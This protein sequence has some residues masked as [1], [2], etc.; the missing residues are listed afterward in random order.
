MTPFFSTAKYMIN[1]LFSAKSIFL[2]WYIK[3]STFPMYPGTCTYFSFRDFSKLLV[4]LVFNELTAIFV[5]LQAI[6]GTK[7]QRAVYEWVNISDDLVYEWVCFI[8]GQVYEGVGFEILARTP[9]PQLP[10]P[11]P[12][13]KLPAPSPP[14][15]RKL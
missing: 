8:K 13:K 7:N 15:P 2:D 10:P 12:H 1:P 6:N 5:Q 3:G 4:L 9:V 14:L 11:P